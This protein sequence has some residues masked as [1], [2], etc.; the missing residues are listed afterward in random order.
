MRQIQFVS[1]WI[2]KHGWLIA[3]LTVVVLA[4]LA[5]L[6]LITKLGVYRDDWHV[7]YG[8][9]IWGPRV[10]SEMFSIDRPFI[11]L[12][13]TF[14]YSLLGD[15]IRLWHLAAFLLRIAGGLVFVAIIRRLWPAMYQAGVLM[16]AL[17]IVYPG[18]MQQANAI[19][20]MVHLTYSV[21]FLLS[22]L[23]TVLAFQAQKLW[24]RVLFTVLAVATFLYYVFLAEYVIGVEGLRIAMLGYLVHRSSPEKP[25]WNKVWK[26]ARVWAP[27]LFAGLFFIFWRFFIFQSDR[28][29]VD[30]SMVFG[31]YVSSPV[32]SL[33]SAAINTLQ[34]F[35][36]VAFSAWFVP[37][38]NLSGEVRL[39]QFVFSLAL[40]LI[41]ALITLLVLS[42]GNKTMNHPEDQENEKGWSKSAIWMGAIGLLASIL[43]VVLSGR[44]V[45]F[46][47]I[48]TSAF[49]RYSLHAAPAAALLVGGILFTAVKPRWRSGW[50]T[51]LVGLAVTTQL[52]AGSIFANAWEYTRQF[53]WQ[54]SWRA[55]QLLPETML[56]AGFPSYSVILEEYQVSYPANMIYYPT[57]TA[58][59]LSAAPLLEVNA[60]KVIMG[61]QEERTRRKVPITSDYDKT[62]V[63][64]FPS[65]TSCLH[66]LEGNLPLLSSGSDPLVQMIAP[67]SHLEQVDVNA[68]AHVP[69]IDVFGPEPQHDWCY[70]FQRGSLAA[71]QGEWEKVASLAGE[72]STAGLKPVDLSEWVPFLLGYINTGNLQRAHE[73]V[74]YIK[75]LDYVR[76]QLCKPLNNGADFPGLSS[77]EARQYLQEDLCQW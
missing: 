60:E 19:T 14:F 55:P 32:Y 34:D 3:G 69:P 54:M 72:A 75:G 36:E 76:Y 47:S 43:P 64:Y 49:D 42:S 16:G 68:G 7:I 65:A 70:Y 24:Q 46:D 13:F 63:A 41:A 5:Y 48:L 35:V 1:R 29:T 27:Y 6:P 71:Q 15:H 26:T 31:R 50:V 2:H 8:G 52:N 23:L 66:L 53:W 58:T 33:L 39:K 56:I 61:V 18:F 10:F 37:F 21:M 30:V 28:P 25:F 74:T 4:T 45:R 22:I 9:K 40:G 51:L 17:W 12:N 62:L 20:Y 57:S 11:G 44:D 73:I 38:Y 67:Y 77:P 59:P